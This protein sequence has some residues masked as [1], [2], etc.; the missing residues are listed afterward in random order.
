MSNL[1]AERLMQQK[2]APGA[3]ETT[4]DPEFAVTL[5]WYM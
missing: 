4:T 1:E 2:T 3:L 5:E